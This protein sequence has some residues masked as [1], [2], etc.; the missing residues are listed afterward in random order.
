MN[1]RDE[2][3]RWNLEEHVANCPGSG[4]GVEL[5]L[6]YMEVGFYTIYLGGAGESQLKYL[7]QG[8]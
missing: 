4:S 5:S 1:A 3:V 8:K 7:D 2:E 6:V